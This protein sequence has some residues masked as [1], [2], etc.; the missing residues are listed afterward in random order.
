MRGI[1]RGGTVH[2]VLARQVCGQLAVDAWAVGRIRLRR[3]LGRRVF[4]QWC[5]FEQGDLRVIQLLAGA[6]VLG[7]TC[8]QQ[9]QREL[10]DHQLEEYHL[11]VAL[12]DDAQ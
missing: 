10:V 2:L 9:L 4:I 1:G 12:L 5:A 8:A 11:G 7:S 3:C 6:A